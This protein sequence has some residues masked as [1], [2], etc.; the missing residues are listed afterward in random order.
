MPLSWLFWVKLNIKWT[1]HTHFKLAGIDFNGKCLSYKLFTSLRSLSSRGKLGRVLMSKNTQNTMK[2]K[3][4]FFESTDCT[5]VD[6][7]M[8]ELLLLF[9]VV[10]TVF[11]IRLMSWAQNCWVWRSN[12]NELSV[13]DWWVGRRSSIERLKSSHKEKRLECLSSFV[14]VVNVWFVWRPRGLFK[15]MPMAKHFW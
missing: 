11:S 7:P 12:E 9:R 14:V 6:A 1:K 5:K 13:R 3:F 10:L 8:L 4:A 15:D 2:S